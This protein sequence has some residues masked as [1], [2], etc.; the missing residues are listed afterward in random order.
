[1]ADKYDIEFIEADAPITEPV[2]KFGGQ[3]VWLEEPEWPLSKE[4]GGQ[5]QFVCQIAL[6]PELIGVSPG[7]VAYLFMTGSAE[8]EYVDGTWEPEGG[9]NAVVVQPSTKAAYGGRVETL[10]SA[11]GPTLNRFA[12]GTR[13]GTTEV[14][15]CE[16]AVN[17]MPGEEP[18]PSSPAERAALSDEQYDSLSGNKIGGEPC[19][20]QG[21]EYPEGDSWKLFL[22][23]E[24]MEVPFF[25]NFGDAGVG[26]AFVSGDGEEGRFLWQCH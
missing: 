16:Y 14:V 18:Y 3:P 17:L 25:I 20:V 8:D 22:Q 7:R 10:P 5:M 23:L 11:T 26:Y 4:S 1:L 19:F 13:G 2:T 24:M 9:E 6:D 12:E 15:S 21:E